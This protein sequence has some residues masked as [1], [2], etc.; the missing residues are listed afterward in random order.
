MTSDSE[1][2]ILKDWNDLHLLLLHFD[3]FGDFYRHLK[4]A[5]RNQG[6]QK[7]IQGYADVDK[8][9]I[10]GGSVE[11]VY[12]II[13]DTLKKQNKPNFMGT[14]ALFRKFWLRAKSIRKAKKFN[15]L[16]KSN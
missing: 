16:D 11:I 13:K 9:G 12:P 8:L 3:N 4:R 6:S 5:A 10:A 14:S 2:K 1:E 7:R 15:R